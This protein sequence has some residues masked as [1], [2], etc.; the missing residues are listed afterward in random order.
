M[1]AGCH[2]IRHRLSTRGSF[3]L[4]CRWVMLVALVTLAGCAGLPKDYSRTTSYALTP[5]N[6]GRIAHVFSK[7]V[8]AHPGLS[9]LYPL[10]DGQDALAARRALIDTAEHSL[11]IQYYIWHQDATGMLLLDHILQAADR[12]VR[13][14][15]L[16]DDIG[17]IPKDETLL[18]IAT[19]PNI[20]IRIFN[21]T[22]TRAFYQLS[23]VLEFERINGRMHNKSMSAD[24]QVT[25]IGGRNIGDEYFGNHEQLNFGDLDVL[26]VG[27][28]VE[29]VEDS[30]DIF[31]NSK[32]SIP[33]NVTAHR[34][35]KPN[36]LKTIRPQLAMGVSKLEPEYRR[37]LDRSALNRIFKTGGW[38]PLDW[39]KAH[40]L[41]DEPNK[42]EN[43]NHTARKLMPLLQPAID[44]T[45]QELVIISSYFI[46]GKEGLAFIRKL[47]QKG[48][49]VRVVTNSI[50]STDV[51]PAHANYVKYRVPLLREGVELYEIKSD[52]AVWSDRK[53][54]KQR[55]KESGIGGSSRSSLHT[56]A[57]V[58]DRK[59]IFIG[60]L[61]LDPRS[62][63]INTEI[64][65]LIDNATLA[66][67]TVRQLDSK[68][69]DNAYR[70]ELKKIDGSDP[71][72]DVRIEWVSRENGR[73][74]RYRSEPNTN[75]FHR[76]AMWFVS[77]PAFESQF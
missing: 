24:S 68:L 76:I 67:N 3:K 11:D 6:N 72:S 71:N 17:N 73:T 1:Q 4:F 31:W 40:V 29:Q 50:T 43:G 46:P 57:F 66:R 54:R 45:K 61:N 16:L 27:A 23:L 22:S 56:K 74:V 19:H 14:R 53:M 2:T 37:R 58:F 26:A 34:E 69:M 70:L 7:E 52:G 42:V 30:F 75:I 51:F 33:I 25:I 60:S 38:L 55:K 32:Y 5:D 62:I 36:A 8:E 12:G 35:A 44:S 47:R 49:N 15:L 64:G 77:L 48:V 21:P 41:Y 9:G 28:V 18:S 65:L 10:E 39:G 59:R 13:V 63:N 20:S